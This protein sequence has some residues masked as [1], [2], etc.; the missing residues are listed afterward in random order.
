VTAGISFGTVASLTRL[1]DSDASPRNY[2][3]F[4]LFLSPNLRTCVKA[5]SLVSICL[6]WAPT[7]SAAPGPRGSAKTVCDAQPAPVRRLPRHPRSFGGPVRPASQL[8][9]L[10]E[11]TAHV[12]RAP[13]NLVDENQA[14][15][16]DA[17]AARVNADDRPVPALR[18]VGRLARPI[19]PRPRT[20]A[21]S[22][23]SPR[24]PPVSA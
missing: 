24:G 3:S 9:S 2:R 12:S 21:C 19:D 5:S 18:V 22:P 6:L 14:I 8:L 13:R 17:P 10:D 4:M 11:L 23:K 15:Q 1:W 7:A 20:H 16:N